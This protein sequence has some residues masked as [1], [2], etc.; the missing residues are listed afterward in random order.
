MAAKGQNTPIA[1]QEFE[2]LIWSRTKAKPLFLARFLREKY[3]FLI[4][5]TVPQYFQ[6]LP[7]LK[8]TCVQVPLPKYQKDVKK[9]PME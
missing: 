8:D 5:F 9:R 2:S 1:Q 6:K 7:I 3:P 4:H